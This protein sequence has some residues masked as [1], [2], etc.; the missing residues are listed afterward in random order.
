MH[1]NGGGQTSMYGAKKT[2]NISVAP[3]IRRASVEFLPFNFV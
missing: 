1:S 2:G 3:R